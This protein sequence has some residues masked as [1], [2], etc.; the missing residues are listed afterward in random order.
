MA[1][2]LGF[3]LSKNSIALIGAQVGDADQDG[4]IWGT[5]SVQEAEAKDPNITRNQHRI[6]DNMQGNSYTTCEV[7]Y[8]LG[9]QDMPT[10]DHPY[11][12]DPSPHQ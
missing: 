10:A 12:C 7:K 11:P 9:A 2:A 5:A 6:M 4:R 3:Q 1:M 8:W